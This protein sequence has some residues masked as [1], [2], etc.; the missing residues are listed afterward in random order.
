M[1]RPD[2]GPW[3]QRFDYLRTL[4]SG[5]DVELTDEQRADS[6]RLREAERQAA[7]ALGPTATGPPWR[8]RTGSAT[9]PP[10]P[11]TELPG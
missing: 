6:A 5:L 2:Y 1:L 3:Q 11:R 10:S 9:A 4:P 7:H 8:R